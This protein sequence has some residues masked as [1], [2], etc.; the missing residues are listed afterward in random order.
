MLAWSHRAFLSLCA[1]TRGVIVNSSH[2]EAQNFSLSQ[3]GRARCKSFGFLNVKH[4]SHYAHNHQT[5]RM[6]REPHVHQVRTRGVAFVW[7]GALLDANGAVVFSNRS[8]SSPSS[9][10]VAMEC[11][12]MCVYSSSPPS[13]PES[14]FGA[15]S[16]RSCQRSSSRM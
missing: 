7:N 9:L 3:H 4:I 12:L 11:R 6:I 8:R 16:T 1:W 5:Y 2:R 10:S 13:R 14:A 15:T